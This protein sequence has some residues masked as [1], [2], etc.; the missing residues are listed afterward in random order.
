[1]K[2]GI[3]RDGL[4]QPTVNNYFKLGGGAD[5]KQTGSGIKR[6]GV[7]STDVQTAAVVKVSASGK[8]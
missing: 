1:M 6:K 7:H 3:K 2:V 5:L 4:L 8:N